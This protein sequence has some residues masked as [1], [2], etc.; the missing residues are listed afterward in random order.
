MKGAGV[1]ITGCI[2]QKMPLL[3]NAISAGES[4]EEDHAAAHVRRVQV[5][6][7]ALHRPHQ[8]FRTLP[9]PLLL[10]LSLIIIFV[11]VAHQQ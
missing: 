2:Q 9:L 1:L 8:S 6:V 10:V 4:D 7:A 11:V 5:R 3:P